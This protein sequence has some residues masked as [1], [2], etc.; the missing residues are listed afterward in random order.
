L[1]NFATRL[2]RSRTELMFQVEMV[3]CIEIKLGHRHARRMPG[4]HVFRAAQT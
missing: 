1:M 4:I 2:M 3:R